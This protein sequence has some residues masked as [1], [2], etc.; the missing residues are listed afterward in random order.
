MPALGALIVTPNGAPPS[1][2]ITA[3]FGK[4]LGKGRDATKAEI[5]AEMA[6][7]IKSIVLQIEGGAISTTASQQIAAIVPPDIVV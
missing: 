6:A 5:Q 3:A 2:R 7:W 4:Y 1:D